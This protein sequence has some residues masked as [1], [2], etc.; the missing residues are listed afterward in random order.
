MAYLV[1]SLVDLRNEIDA[2]WPGRKRY[3]DGWY[4]KRGVGMKSEHWPDWKGAVHAL[5]ITREG[6]DPYAI[7]DAGRRTPE[8]C[9]YM[10]YSRTLYSHTYG[11]KP[12]Y[13]VSDGP[14]LDHIHVSVR[15]DSAHENYSHGW[16]LY[17]PRSGHPGPP[18]WPSDQDTAGW[19][20]S[21]TI[22]SSARILLDLAE[23]AES[24]AINTSKL[25]W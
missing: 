25:A 6:V 20:Y 8:A 11:W 12:R 15:L 23:H 17:V 1:R 7:I 13:I 2:R 3:R 18:T 22:G 14:H 19:D 16:G 24:T 9:W 4:R 5:D 10:I 21:T